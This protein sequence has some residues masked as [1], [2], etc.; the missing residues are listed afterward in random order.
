MRRVSI[1]IRELMIMQGY[2]I[3]DIDPWFHART[4][5]AD[6]T[7]HYTVVPGA[8]QGVMQL[9]ALGIE[10]HA[11]IATSSNKLWLDT[12]RASKLSSLIP[13][14]RVVSVSRPEELG[15]ALLNTDILAIVDHRLTRLHSPWKA[16]MEQK[17]P[18]PTLLLYRFDKRA[19][20]EERHRV[21]MAYD[22]TLV[23]TW[24]EIADQLH[25]MLRQRYG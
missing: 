15:V 8:V 24:R 14:H 7:T 18:V 9:Q 6:G 20:G 23:W 10:V 1:G 21:S 2:P 22:V 3:R 25:E 11:H 4:H 5:R 17:V 13:R 19:E 16:A 12:F